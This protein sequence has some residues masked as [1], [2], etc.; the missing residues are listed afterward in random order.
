MLEGPRHLV[1][2]DI[3]LT[4]TAEMADVVFPAAAAWAES[5]GT[6]TSSE[7]RVQRVRKAAVSPPGEARDDIDILCD[8]AERSGDPG[9]RGPRTCGTS[10]ARCRRCTRG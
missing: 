6:V 1:V 7:R 4:R 5:D 9:P 8:L 2:Q 3:F 10:C